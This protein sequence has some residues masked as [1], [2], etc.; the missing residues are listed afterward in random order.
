MTGA[1]G[2]GR[3]TEEES[4]EGRRFGAYEVLEV[5]GTGGMGTVY[6]ANNVTLE[7]IVALKTL[8]SLL[9]ANSGF[10]QRFLKEARVVARLNHPN[11]VQI[12]DFGCVDDIHY[13]A[14]EYVD[15]QSLRKQLTLGRFTE[16]DALVIIRQAVRALAVA[17]GQG[18]VHRD[19]KPDNI[20]LTLQGDVK[21]VDLGIAK[22]VEEDQSLTL[23]G[24]AVGTPHYISPEQ[25]RGQRDIDGRADIY[26]LGATFYHLVTG[27]APYKGTSG[28][29]VM[30]MHLTQPLKDP[31][32]Y[33][34]AL[35]EGLC[36]ILRK[37]MAKEREERYQDVGA[38]DRD[39]YRVQ[40][41]EM[42]EAQEPSVSG[43]S[44]MSPGFETPSDELPPPLGQSFSRPTSSRT[45]VAPAGSRPSGGPSMT[46][47]TATSMTRAS[48]ATSG[49]RD[50]TPTSLP[51]FREE[52]LHF[53][54]M[55][56]ARQIGPLARVL[57]KKAAK[58][59]ESLVALGAALEHN[60]SDEAAR[61]TFRAAVRAR[62]R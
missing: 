48:G 3:L 49:M 53:V 1:P 50:S 20:M 18:I 24:Q 51:A 59:A 5:L 16:R 17:H 36:M 60:I 2:G 54:E 9:S 58:T 7:R 12:Y 26:S 43:I 31:R 41:G 15:G 10:V 29:L 42:P 62:A 13:I 14:M 57:V 40:I 39:L 11:I 19:I 38:L 37:M 8:S 46:R 27:R 25:I 33:E 28:A 21:L 35:S 32:L 52:D 44:T 23:T 55:E 34:P 6:R 47:S 45:R 22:L 61:Q 56:L 4:L 30:S